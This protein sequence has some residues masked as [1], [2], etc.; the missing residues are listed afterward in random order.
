MPR[1]PLRTSVLATFIALAFGLLGASAHAMTFD[2]AMHLAAAASLNDTAALAKIRGAAQNGDVNAQDGL[3]YMYLVG[4]GVR[5]G[6]A[7]AAVWYRKAAE[8]GNPDAQTTLGIMYSNGSGVPQD[9]AQA[10][11]WLSKAADQSFAPAEDA[12]GTMY[13]KGWGVPQ[14]DVIAYAL[15]NISATNTSQQHNYAAANREKL[16]AQMTRRQLAEGQSLTR[17]MLSMGVLNAIK[18]MR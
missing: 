1:Q 11:S 14:D 2:Q 16:G 15:Y 17:R 12:L 7:Q 5:Q 18:S 4:W 13:A 10:V 8:Q 9:Y 3:G 6:D